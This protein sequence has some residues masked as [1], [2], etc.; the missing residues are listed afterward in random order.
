[1]AIESV[2][3]QSVGN[4]EKAKADRFFQQANGM[5]LDLFQVKAIAQ[6]LNDHPSIND[7][8]VDDDVA[9]GILAILSIA[10]RACG[11]WEGI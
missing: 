9:G 5:Y 3:Q 7:A 1:M 11:Q 6:M 4:S 2:A 8:S 10:Q